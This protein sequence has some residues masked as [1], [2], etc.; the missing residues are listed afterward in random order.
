ML[1]QSCRSTFPQQPTPRHIATNPDQ[2]T[3]ATV[4]CDQ[5]KERRSWFKE[6]Y[7]HPLLSHKVVDEDHLGDWQDHPFN[8]FAERNN[9]VDDASR[10]K[11]AR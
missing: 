11:C 7:N 9:F 10:V 2:Q 1:H 6:P 8:C 4:C 3:L 5:R